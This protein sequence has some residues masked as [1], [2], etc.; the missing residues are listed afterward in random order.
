MF[1]A[2]ETPGFS[3]SS[4]YLWFEQKVVMQLKN[5][6][7]RIF[8]TKVPE[9]ENRSMNFVSVKCFYYKPDAILYI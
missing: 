4:M 6:L 1:K 5:H 3:D 9:K 2:V 7:R 8:A